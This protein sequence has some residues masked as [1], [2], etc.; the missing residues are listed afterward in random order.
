M[1]R[2][3]FMAHL[4]R[5]VLAIWP[6]LYHCSVFTLMTSCSS[7]IVTDRRR[8]S[9]FSQEVC[10]SHK[11]RQLFSSSNDPEIIALT[12]GSYNAAVP[13]RVLK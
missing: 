8:S 13:F 5:L 2:Q 11:D 7:K 3:V 9:G 12:K 4:R 6:T 10:F 1:I